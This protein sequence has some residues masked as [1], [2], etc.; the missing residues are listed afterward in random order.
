MAL[1]ERERKAIETHMDTFKGYTIDFS[2]PSLKNEFDIFGHRLRVS[3]DLSPLAVSSF[4]LDVRKLTSSELTLV[5]LV[6][7]GRP[8]QPSPRRS[9]WPRSS[10]G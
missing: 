5:D 10:S 2:N 4:S 6:E 1:T 9:S 7:T 3:L 8:L